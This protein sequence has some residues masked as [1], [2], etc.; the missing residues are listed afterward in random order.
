MSPPVAQLRGAGAPEPPDGPSVRREAPP[1]VER[2]TPRLNRHVHRA[3]EPPSGSRLSTSGPR[4]AAVTVRPAARGC[5]RPARGS[6]LSPSGPRLAAVNVRPVAVPEPD[7]AKLRR[8]EPCRSRAPPGG[9]S[10]WTPPR[11]RR[12]HSP[13]RASPR[14]QPPGGAAR[15]RRGQRDAPPGRAQRPGRRARGPR[16]APRDLPPPRRAGRRAGAGGRDAGERPD[17]VADEAWASRTARRAAGRRRRASSR[18]STASPAPP[19]SRSCCSSG[20]PTRTRRRARSGTWSTTRRCRRRR[21]TPR[22]GSLEAYHARPRPDRARRRDAW[23]SCCAP[24][25]GPIPRRSPASCATSASTGATLLGDGAGRA[26]RPHA[27]DP[28]RHRRGGARAPPA[29]RWRRRTAATAVAA[30]RGEAP[31]L[32]GLDAEPE[33]FSSRLRVD[34]APGPDRQEHARLA[35]PAVAALRARHPDA[36]RDPGRGAGPARP[37]GHHRALADR[38]VG[39]VRG[40]RSGSRSGAATRTRRRRRTRSTTTRSPT[41]WAARTPGRTCATGPGRAASGSRRTWC[42]TTWASTPAGSSS[43]RSGSCPSPS[44]PTPRYT[45]GGENLA[46]HDRVEVRLEDHY[47]DNSDAAVVLRAAR[48]RIGRAAL[49]LPRQRRHELPLERHRAAGLQPGGRPGAGDPGDPRGRPP[50]PG[51]PLRRR[52]GAGAAARPAAVVPGPRRGRRRRSRRA[53]SSGR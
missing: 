4:L 45:F 34:A 18:T 19:A 5:H 31:D 15:H 32:T 42:P 46:E 44:R 11:P 28:R 13:T 22:C 47:W 7:R 33:R 10:A 51:H 41:T 20:S 39:A 2:A 29:V 12:R 52:D 1:G 23:W 38:P 50:V 53:P 6:R 24:R 9:A 30:G 8:C 40:R 37:L 16:A 17:A 49:H 35:G 3:V 21:A 14:G 27:A 43:T 25:R 26:P 48:P 36:G